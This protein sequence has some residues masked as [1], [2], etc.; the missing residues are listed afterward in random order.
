MN[1]IDVSQSCGV[2]GS[3]KRGDE[4]CCFKSNGYV[5]SNCSRMSHTMGMGYGVDAKV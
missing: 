2:R 5:L 3:L 4:E 1:Q